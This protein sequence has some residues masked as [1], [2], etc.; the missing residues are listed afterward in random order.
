MLITDSD[1]AIPERTQNVVTL[2]DEDFD[3]VVRADLELIK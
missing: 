2:P 3:K 1:L